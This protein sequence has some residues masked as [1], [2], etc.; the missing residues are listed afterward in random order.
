MFNFLLITYLAAHQID[1]NLEK[2]KKAEVHSS[3]VTTAVLEQPPRS[4]HKGATCRVQ[5]DQQ[6][7]NL[8]HCQLGQ[9]IPENIELE[10]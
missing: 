5:T 7:P 4:H 2:V 6:Y 8:W 10:I 9:D 3:F 1:I